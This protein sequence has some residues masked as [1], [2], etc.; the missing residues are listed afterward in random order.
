MDDYTFVRVDKNRLD[1]IR[2][3]YLSSFGLSVTLSFLEAK[4]STGKFG[5]EFLGYLAY[6]AEGVPAAYYGLFPMVARVDGTSVL[7]AQSGD[8]MTSPEH[9]MKGLFVKA[10]KKTYELAKKEGVQFVFGFPNENSFPGF[11]SKLDWEFIDTLY[12]FR[13]ET[14]GLPFAA[15]IKKFPRLHGLLI[16]FINAHLDRIRVPISDALVDDFFVP[17]VSS[18]Q[19]DRSFFEYKVQNGAV[20]VAWKSFLFYIKIDGVLIIGDV[21]K[22]ESSE[23]GAFLDACRTLGRYL[24]CHR[25]LFSLSKNHWLFSFFQQNDMQG[26]ESLPIGFLPLGDQAIPFGT[27]AFSRMDADTF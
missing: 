1:D 14:G 10:A 26:K 4:Y 7:V 27:I 23:F 13:I 9:R 17:M 2:K 22:F 12:D 20:P 21:A 5:A 3:L 24:Y 11:K 19:H 8:T 15:V 25:I 6:S 18:V 16:G